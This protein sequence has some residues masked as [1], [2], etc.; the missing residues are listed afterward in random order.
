MGMRDDLLWRRFLHTVAMQMA[1]RRWHKIQELAHGLTIAPVSIQTGCGITAH[2][3]HARRI[4]LNSA[5]FPSSFPESVSV[6]LL[7]FF[8]Y[9]IDLLKSPHPPTQ[10]TGETHTRGLGTSISLQGLGGGEI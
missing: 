4:I 3:C 7:P 6:T 5:S 8:C 9:N 1:F 10:W 2:A